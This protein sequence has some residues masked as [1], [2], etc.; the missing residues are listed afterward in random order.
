[1]KRK[2]SK[3]SNK[4]VKGSVKKRRTAPLK[5]STNPKKNKLDIRQ[6]RFCDEIVLG[7]SITSAAISAGYSPLTANKK[8]YRWV[9][10]SREESFYPQMW[11]YV[12][13]KR[14]KIAEKYELTQEKLALELGKIIFSTPKDLFKENGQLK[15]IHEMD[16]AAVNMIAGFELDEVAISEKITT[17]TKKVKLLKKTEAISIAARMMG[18]N[19]PDK[20]E[21]E[22]GNS[23]LE[24]LKASSGQK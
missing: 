13:A 23:F 19:A 22:A 7:K 15:S 9:G 17:V 2:L 8:A 4:P 10:D 5:H 1:M 16:S 24:F 18:F 3:P 21:H 11:D 12:E 20:H 6:K 14:K